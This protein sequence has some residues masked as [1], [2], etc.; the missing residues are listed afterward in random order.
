MEKE[1]KN[2][3]REIGRIVLLAAGITILIVI[4]WPALVQLFPTVQKRIALPSPVVVSY[5]GDDSRSGLL[6]YR[7]RVWAEIRN[8]GGDGDVVVEATMYQGDKNWT[9]S[10]RRYMQAKETTRFE[11]TFEE[12]KWLGGK[13]TYS[14]N[15]YGY[16]K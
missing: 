1:S 3:K 8:D 15:A 14:V 5:G 4:L 9:K 10:S 16:G 2:L 13:V 6:Q 12:V 11:L 7:G